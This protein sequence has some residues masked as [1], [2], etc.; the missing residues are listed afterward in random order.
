M[1]SRRLPNLLFSAVI[2]L[3]AGCAGTNK[4]IPLPEHPRPDFE[5]ENF[6]N[7]NGNW[8]FTFDSALADK[9]IGNN[10][11]AIM[12]EN[13]TVPFPWG[14]KLS[15]VED[16]ADIAWY[17]RSFDVPKSWKGKRVFVIV[18]AADWETDAWIDG[19]HL[20]T[21]QGGY[22]PFEFEITDYVDYGAKQNLYFRI[23]DTYSD[24]HLYGKQGY[25][26]A[27]GIWQTVYLEARGEQYI[28]ILHFSP[29]IDNSLVGVDVKLSEAP[30]ADAVFELRFPNGERKSVCEQFDG[31]QSLHI[32]IPL[33][34]QHLWT[35]DDPYLY[36]TEAVV[37]VDGK[38]SDKVKSYFGQR[39]IGTVKMPGEEYWYIALNNEPIYLQL[40][41]DQSYNPD[42]FYTFPSDEFMKNEILLSKRLGLNGNRIHIKAELPRK[43]YWA[44]KLGLLIMADVPN[45]WGEPVAEAKQ[46]WERCMRGQVERDFNHPSIFAWVNFNET[47]GLFSDVNGKD[48]YTTETQEWV[49]D[50]YKLTK[51]L[52]PTRLVEDNSVCNYDHTLTDINSW[53][54]YQ[55]GHRWEETV[56]RYAS[57]CRPGSDYNFAEGY[58]C[59]DVPVINSE[60]G[61]VWGYDGSAGDCDFSWDYHEMINAF[62]RHLNTAGWLYTEHHDVINEWNGYVQ[63]DRSAKYDGLD[64]FVPGMSI[65]DFQ[66]HYYIVNGGPVCIEAGA[67]SMQPAD[68]WSSFTTSANPGKLI[69]EYRLTG[70][71]CLGRPLPEKDWES[72]AVDFKP[73]CLNAI[74][75]PDVQ[76]PQENGLYVLQL[77]LKDADDNVLHRNFR[78]FRVK[79]A[80][81][82]QNTI[83]FSPADFCDSE[84]SQKQTSVLDGLKVDGFG[85]GK[86]DYR[87]ALPQEAASAKKA[88]LLFEASAKQLF[89]KDVSGSEI[90]GSYM[91]GGG[92]YDHCKSPN[93][94]A[95]TDDD[96]W[97]S[98]VQV[99][100]NGID[101]GTFVLPDDPADHRGALSWFSQPRDNWMR[102]A[103]SYGTLIS[104]DIP[105]ETLSSGS[106][107]IRFSVPESACSDKSGGLALYGKDFGRYPLDPTIVFE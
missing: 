91:L 38:D 68:L 53:H 104:V 55:T 51:Q 45:Y 73:F 47:W 83:S 58:V 12:D 43:L 56:N 52:D 96:L 5:R 81:V 54:R 44:D 79:D 107:T 84:W 35:L 101:A 32:D 98:E 77:V 65:C 7:L 62:H 87:I 33:E 75:V 78:L 22:T 100:I 10:D 90:K 30:S 85:S 72:V 42:G 71:D 26:N 19:T 36:E 28:D 63:Y 25:G 59:G 49:A 95:M 8:N 80:P 89:G 66:S 21:H 88:T 57:R 39:K 16:K 74:S 70:T 69:L 103:G 34:N 67:G 99:S 15:G 1:T 106:L 14:S 17:G 9:A 13:I 61:N 46:D 102:E 105:T 2:F 60:C 4:D 18:G 50:M 3:F 24:A 48:V 94:Y 23:D 76:L 6:V 40:C 31:R 37:R 82:P 29:D 97:P 11:P 20:G 93:S 86:F 64:D 41:L 92:T 27:R